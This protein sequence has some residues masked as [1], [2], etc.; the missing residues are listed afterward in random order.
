M[1]AAAEVQTGVPAL[2][3]ER[4]G[5][6]VQSMA[7]GG[8][9][10]IQQLLQLAI[11]KGTGFEALEKLVDL[12][13]RVTK[14]EAALE[15]NRALTAF[16]A[17]CPAIGKNKTAQIATRSGGSYSYQYAPLE[18]IA[19][20]VKPL[21]IKHGFS[22]GWASSVDG[23]MLTCI[24]TLRH[25]N[26]HSESAPFTLP[27]DNPSAMSPQQKMGAALSFAQRKTL[28]SVLGLNTTEEDSDGVA[29]EVDPTPISDDQLT[30]LE[31]LMEE[32]GADRARFLRFLAVPKLGDLPATRFQEA[33]NALKAK[34]NRKAQP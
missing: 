9:G 27:V 25:V 28:E 12:H 1:S 33:K 24:C 34:K 5:N 7:E 18:E 16:Q 31:D 21:L 26:G 11:E 32:I 20:I 22:Y 8:V 6:G 2:R 15:F 3:D 29:R 10:S 13:E 17:E 19:R 30:E 23:A 4:G 14:R